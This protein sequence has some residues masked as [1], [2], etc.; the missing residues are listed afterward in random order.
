MC[1]PITP[2]TVGD[3][4]YFMLLVDDCTRWMLVSILK[5]KDQACSAFVKFKAE[6]EN[7]LGYKI[8]M[9]RSNRGGELLATAFRDVCETAGIK[10]QFTAPYSPQQNGVV[11]R[12]NRTVMEMARSILKGMSVPGC[13]W[14]EAVRHS[15]HLLNRLP[16]KVMGYRTPFEGWCGRK[17]QLG[18]MRVF[19]CRANVRPAVPHLKKLD[20]RSVGMV[21]FGV[22]EGSKAHRLYNPQTKKIVVS[23]DVIFEEAVAWNWNSE[24]GENSKFIVEENDENMFQPWTR[25][26]FGGG[27]VDGDN[28]SDCHSGGADDGHQFDAP[29][30]NNFDGATKNS[31]GVGENS[32]LGSVHSQATGATASESAE[33]GD[34]PAEMDVDGT[35]D[36]DD[37]PMRFRNLN[38]V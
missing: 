30:G 32:H 27:H 14:G 34:V 21:Y 17:P 20:D 15:V 7:S 16:T 28:H 19:G 11:E 23:R 12:R 2:E 29:S 37:G 8:K 25:G 33:T 18:H 4:K 24:F 36:I 1:G 10:R 26:Q 22:E 5:S 9:V 35:V 38:E 6:A 31:S 3:N 13:F